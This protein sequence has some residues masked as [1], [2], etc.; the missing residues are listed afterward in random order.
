MLVYVE[1][2]TVGVIG[3]A[4]CNPVAIAVSDQSWFAEEETQFKK[5]EE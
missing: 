1:K 4:G 2:L 3:E 5:N